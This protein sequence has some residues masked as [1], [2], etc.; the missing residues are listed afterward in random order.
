MSFMFTFFIEPLPWGS[1]VE[2]VLVEGQ[3]YVTKLF[4]IVL[5]AWLLSN[6]TGFD[7]F[8]VTDSLSSLILA[9]WYLQQ[10]FLSLASS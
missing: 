2:V 3:T 6:F 8:K 9:F 5:L 1:H 4:V 10:S 7:L